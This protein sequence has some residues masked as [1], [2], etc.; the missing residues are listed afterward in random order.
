MS[1][2]KSRS[3]SKKNQRHRLS[4]TK[5][6]QVLE[7]VNIID[8]NPKLSYNYEKVKRIFDFTKANQNTQVKQYF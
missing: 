3:K 4:S 8:S 7:S 2:N 5:R 6:K 1:E